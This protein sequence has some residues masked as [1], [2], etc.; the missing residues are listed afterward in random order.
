MSERAALW[1]CAVLLFCCQRA[2]LSVA[3]G[4]SCWLSEVQ[5]RAAGGRWAPCAAGFS[6]GLFVA[7]HRSR[8]AWLISATGKHGLKPVA[9]GTRKPV[10]PVWQASWCLS[11]DG[12]QS[13]T[14]EAQSTHRHQL[15]SVMSQTD[16]SFLRGQ[17][18]TCFSAPTCQPSSTYRQI[19][20]LARYIA[21][22]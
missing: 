19:H 13:A 22:I 10:D 6:L 8:R 2:R 9:H 7:C 5:H 4:G 16:H 3:L 11:V 15:T 21:A 14:T 18:N 12:S 20:I 1:L 17:D